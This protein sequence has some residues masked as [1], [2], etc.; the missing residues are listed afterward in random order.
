MTRF[1]QTIVPLRPSK[2][3]VCI[4]ALFL[5]LLP[6]MLNAAQDGSSDV[7]AGK[8]EYPDKSTPNALEPSERSTPE[9]RRVPKAPPTTK[10]DPQKERTK[11]SSEA[12]VDERSNPLIK[13]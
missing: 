6:G 3:R 13:K 8:Q 5:L 1:L 4:S 12:T 9:V 7:K 2:L 10:L 11:A